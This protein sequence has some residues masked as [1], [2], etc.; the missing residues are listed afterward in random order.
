MGSTN[1]LSAQPAFG[2]K[3]SHWTENGVTLGVNPILSTVVYSNRLFVAHYA[4]AHLI[5]VVTNRR[6][7]GGLTAVSGAGTFGNGQS[8]PSPPPRR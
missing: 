5:H 7:A 8:P 3:F 6:A 4:E 2:Y 1:T